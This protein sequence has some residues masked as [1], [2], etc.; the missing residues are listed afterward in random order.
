MPPSTIIYADVGR[1]IIEEI[2]D[3]ETRK[4]CALLSRAFREVAHKAL[5]RS[6]TFRFA[7]W[8]NRSIWQRFFDVVQENPALA[9]YIRTLN[10]E[11]PSFVNPEWLPSGKTSPHNS[12]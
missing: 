6:T 5:F 3:D 9:T 10:L 12:M 2:N 7:E 11:F 4:S 1:L 8:N